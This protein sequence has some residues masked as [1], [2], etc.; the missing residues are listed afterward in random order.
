VSILGTHN[1]D[2]GA[3]GIKVVGERRFELPTSCSRTE[4]NV[5]S[6]ESRVKREK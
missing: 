3:A 2:V 1:F 4:I 6:R 5:N